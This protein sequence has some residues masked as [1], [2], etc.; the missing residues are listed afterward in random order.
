MCIRDRRIDGRRRPVSLWNDLGFS[1]NP[2]GADPLPASE[3]GVQ[4]LV[5]RDRELR[6]LISQLRSTDTHPTIEGD[7]GVGKTSLVFVAAFTG[8]KSFL[9]GQSQQLLLPFRY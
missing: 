6:H 7:N 9:A 8:R 4:L 1:S 3:E 2:Y 5:G